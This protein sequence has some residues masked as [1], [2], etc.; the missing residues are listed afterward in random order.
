MNQQIFEVNNDQ[1]LVKAKKIRLRSLRIQSMFNYQ[2]IPQWRLVAGEY[3]AS[4]PLGW[5]NNTVTQCGAIQMLGGYG[6]FAGGIT[7]KTF[8]S[9]GKHSI[10]KV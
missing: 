3:F 7:R 4:N 1:I 6:R 5:S 2:S 9:L 8:V 10:L